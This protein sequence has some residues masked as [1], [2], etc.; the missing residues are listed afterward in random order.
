MADKKIPSDNSS[1]LRYASFATQLTVVLVLAV[2]GGRWLDT[3][4]GFNSPLFVWLLP[5]F[6]LVGMLIKLVRDLSKKS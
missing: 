1:L 6:L 2:Y 4:A 3:K 5:L